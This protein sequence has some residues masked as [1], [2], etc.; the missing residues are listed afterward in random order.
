M[1]FL[2]SHVFQEWTGSFFKNSS[3]REVGHVVQL[4]HNPRDPCTNPERSSRAFTVLHVNGVHVI[5]LVFCCCTR[6]GEH[7][8]RVQQLLRRRLLPA[9]TQDP[10]TA[11]T[12]Q[13][14][15]AAHVLSVQSKLSL[16]D[17]YLSIEQLTD[18]TSTSNPKVHLSSMCALAR[19][20]T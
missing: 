8:S 20:L 11:C 19:I 5:N 12:F 14:L 10:N 6:I 18:A 17:Y 3:L 4:G 2:L 9:T 13:L 1:H 15:S 7:G 16:Y